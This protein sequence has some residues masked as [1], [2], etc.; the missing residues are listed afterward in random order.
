V[1]LSYSNGTAQFDIILEN[2]LLIKSVNYNDNDLFNDIDK[3]DA[4]LYALVYLVHN[5]IRSWPILM[6]NDKIVSIE[7]NRLSA[8]SEKLGVSFDAPKGANYPDKYRSSSETGN[9]EEP[10]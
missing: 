5:I 2:Q 9:N 6:Q 4:R 10:F 3:G 7:M 1:C 8:I